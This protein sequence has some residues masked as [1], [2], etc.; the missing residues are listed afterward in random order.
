MSE[1]LNITGPGDPTPEA[2]AELIDGMAKLYSPPETWH[3]ENWDETTLMWFRNSGKSECE[4]LRKLLLATPA[5][6][7]AAKQRDEALE[8]LRELHDLYIHPIQPWRETRMRSAFDKAA[9][10]LTQTGR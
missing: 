2:I 4:W 7:G 10:L 8:L 6:L 9:E 5:L 1:E 3:P